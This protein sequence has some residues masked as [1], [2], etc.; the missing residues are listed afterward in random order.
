MSLGKSVT[1]NNGLKMPLIGLGTY[2]SKP[3]EVEDAVAHALKIGY[4]HI[5]CAR[6]YENEAE[7][8]RG[9]KKSGVPRE[10][11]FITSKIWNNH[12]RPEYARAA[13][14]GM[15][16]DLQVDYVDQLLIHW[17][18]AFKP[19]DDMIPIDKATGKVIIDDY[20]ISEAWKTY[21]QFLEEGK[22]KSIGVSNFNIKKL[23]KLLETAKVPPAANQVELHAYLQQPELVKYCQGKGIAVVAWAPLGNQ[24]SPLSIRDKVPSKRVIDDPKVKEISARVKADPAQVLLAWFTHKNIVAIPKSVTPSRIETNFKQIVLD[25][26]SIAEI[27]ALEKNLRV[28]PPAWGV[29][30]FDQGPEVMDPIEKD[31]IEARLAGKAGL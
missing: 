6:F 20:P 12:R 3:K 10:E 23:E 18:I 29:D 25:A 7:V 30:I 26:E 28:D 19:G 1:L 5:D 22:V 31:A 4:R 15:L 11:I 27:D 2:L 24:A 16:K 13:L 21:E 8:G 17:P 14:E 9:I